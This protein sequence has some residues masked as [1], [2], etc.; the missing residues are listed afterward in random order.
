MVPQ[1][2]RTQ[3][4]LQDLGDPVDRPLCVT[5]EREMS[6]ILCSQDCEPGAGLPGGRFL[7]QVERGLHVETH[8]LENHSGQ[9]DS[10]TCLTSKVKAILDAAQ[11]PSTKRSYVYKW[12]CYSKFI[13]GKGF[14]PINAP[15]SAVLDFLVSLSDS[16]LSLSSLKCYLAAIAWYRRKEGLPSLFSDHLVKLFLRGFGNVRPTVAP[17]TPS[18]SLEVVLSSLQSSPYN[19][20]ATCEISYLT[21]KTAFLVAITSARRVSEICALRSDEPYLRFHKDKVILHTGISFLPKVTSRFHMSQEIV[22]PAFFQSPTTSLERGLHMLDVRRALAFYL[23]RTKDV[24]KTPRLFVKYRRDSCSLPV[25]SQRLSSW[26]VSVIKLAYHKSGRELPNGVKGHSTRAVSTTAA[27]WKG[28]P[29]DAIC[30]AATWSTPS[31]FVTNYKLDLMAK[32]DA[33]FGRAVLFSAVA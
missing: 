14:D 31:T 13:V 20:M 10:S 1:S 7:T 5:R 22:L 4:D 8:C 3:Y 18:W 21:W 30:R 19:P 16:G 11:K 12:A 15:I 9:L 25:S 29:L 17:I 23:S 26:V 33:E 28:V 27:F 24:R 2:K 32:K 6:P